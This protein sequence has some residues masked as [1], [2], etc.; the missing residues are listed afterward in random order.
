MSQNIYTRV[1]QTMSLLPLSLRR[2]RNYA[3]RAGFLSFPC[4]LLFAALILTGVDA[5]AQSRFR[6]TYPARPN[7]RLELKNR[8]GTIEVIGWSSNRIEIVATR[9]SP[10]ATFTPRLTDDRLE[11][12]VMRDNDGRRIGDVN[13]TIRVPFN[14]A[15]DLETT[16][17]GIT[18]RGLQGAFVRAHVTEGDIELTNIHS[19]DVNAES[20][21]GNIL[22]DGVLA[23][24]G[25]YWF[26]CTQGD[27]TVRLPGNSSFAFNG[28]AKQIEM[29]P[30]ARMGQFATADRQRVIG[31]IKDGSASFSVM[32]MRGGVTMM[33]R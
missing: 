11:I 7:V 20:R 27:I 15:V 14:A 5:S 31:K 29:G 24:R 3:R 19:N 8:N 6:E 18:V 10:A 16:S 32:N 13:F 4:P 25:S 30:F 23:A 2:H 12:N 9:E 26:Q 33:S 17:G 22:F 1:K 28:T 21:T